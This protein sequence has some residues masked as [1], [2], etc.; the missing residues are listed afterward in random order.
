MHRYPERLCLVQI[1]SPSGEYVIDPIAI[2]DPAPLGVL[3]ADQRVEKVIHSADYDLRSLDREWGFRVRSLFDTSIAAKFTTAPRLAL[4]TLLQDTLGIDIVKD[5][6]M[7][8]SDWSNRPLSDAALAYAADDVAHLLALRDSQVS[9]LR[10]LDREAWVAEECA[11]M[12]EIHFSPPS[13][14][15]VAF[16]AMKG[17][18]GLD[19]RG[20]AVLRELVVFR[21]AQARRRGVPPYRIVSNDALLFLAR[22][23]EAGLSDAPGI[24]E[25][26]MRRIGGGL[27]E[28]LRE[29]RAAEPLSRPKP[30][31]PPEPRPTRVQA[32]RFKALRQWRI[33]LGEELGLDPALLWPMASLERLARSPRTLDG[34]LSSPDVRRWQRAEFGERIRHRLAGL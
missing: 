5:T 18:H 8:H 7:Q 28:A 11:R 9:K 27:Q 13:P 6:R 14:P 34:E 16:L 20:L 17:S 22:N 12:E 33:Q 2:D 15:E 23:P 21:D 26:A 19:G 30:A 10:S 3:L 24:G 4:D 29:G 31:V 25:S 1:A 32:E